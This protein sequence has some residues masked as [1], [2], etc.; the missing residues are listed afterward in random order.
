MDKPDVTWNDVE[1]ML[2]ENGEMSIDEITEEFYEGEI[3]C[4]ECGRVMKDYHALRSD[5]KDALGIGIDKGLLASTPDWN[6][7]LAHK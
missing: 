4:P 1:D 5:V 7:R 2:R 6:Y 3:D